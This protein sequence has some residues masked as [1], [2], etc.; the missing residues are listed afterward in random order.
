M[1]WV[2]FWCLLVVVVLIVCFLFLFL[3]VVYVEIFEKFRIVLVMKLLVNEFF[4]IMEDGVK[5]YQKEYVDWFELVFNGIKDE[6]DIFSQICIVEQMIV[7]GVD[8][9]VIVL[10]DFKVLVLVVKKVLDVGIVVVNIDNCFD[11][12]VLQVKKIG[13]F[14]VGFDN[15]KGVWLVGE[16]LVK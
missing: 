3:F 1:K 8:V 4:L 5:V 6:I 13:V 10:V 11:L 9:L 16:Y 15:C 14:F 12:Q 7:F 2:V